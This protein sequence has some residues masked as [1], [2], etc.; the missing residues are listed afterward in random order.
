MFGSRLSMGWLRVVGISAV[1]IGGGVAQAHVNAQQFVLDDDGGSGDCPRYGAPNPPTV[2]TPDR[3]VGCGTIRIDWNNPPLDGTHDIE[4]YFHVYRDN[5]RITPAAGTPFTDWIDTGP[6]G[7]FEPGRGY[8]YHIVAVNCRGSSSPTAPVEGWTAESIQTPAELTA[9]NEGGEVRLTWSA[10]PDPERYDLFR[11]GE[12]IL[13]LGPYVTS[14]LYAEAECGEHQYCVRA[15]NCRGPSGQRCVTHSSPVVL[16]PTA[17]V[18]ASDSGSTGV[19]VSWSDANG[20]TEYRIYRN[21]AYIDTVAEDVTSYTDPSGQPTSPPSGSYEYCVNAYRPD[22]G[23]VPGSCDEGYMPEGTRPPAPTSVAASDCVGLGVTVTWDDVAGE[24]EYRV[25][26]EGVRIATVGQDAT[27]YFDPGQESTSPPPGDYAYCVRSFRP[28]GGESADTCDTGCMPPP[29]PSWSFVGNRGIGGMDAA[30]AYDSERQR[31]LLFGGQDNFGTTSDVWQF[32]MSTSTPGWGRILTVG[33]YGAPGPTPRSNAATVYS[34]GHDAL[35]AFGGE[36]FSSDALWKLSF[37][38]ASPTWC[39][40]NAAGTPPLTAQARAVHDP[41]ANRMI[42]ISPYQGVYALSLS[43]F[44]WSTIWSGSMVPSY[45]G[46]YGYQWLYDPN[47]DRLLVRGG[48]DFAGCYTDTVYAMSLR[49]ASPTWTTIAT[50]GPN[51]IQDATLVY[52]PE[53]QRAL[54]FGGGDGAQLH[55]DV[56]ELSLT[57]TPTWSQLTVAGSAPAA[58]DRHAAHFDARSDRMLIFGGRATPWPPEGDTW[59][60]ETP[61]AAAPGAVYDLAPELISPNDIGMMWTAPGD[62]G[63][64]GT[65]E[66]YD[67]RIAPFPITESNFGIATEASPQPLTEPAGSYQQQWFRNLQPCTPYYFAIKTRDEAGQWSALSNVP[68]VQTLCGGGGVL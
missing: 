37:D 35:I 33:C 51:A 32:D 9:M 3:G 60:L 15:V 44:S 4:E 13:P 29:A 67:L 48:C 31:V 58:R 11:D 38:G 19:S 5:Q 12:L 52:D 63:Y 56:W 47:G 7:G 68:A 55:D 27:S 50:A 26:R 17:N 1:L 28:N 62:D 64:S 41:V 34:P 40:I 43:N 25:Y 24:T 54:F 6:S 23:E 8:W 18:T 42:V 53:G 22:C 14:V 45:I 39:P 65:A 16:Q 59:L 61:D 10:V 36:P 66:L 21:G 57:G 20:E 2:V 46:P 49:V 30:T